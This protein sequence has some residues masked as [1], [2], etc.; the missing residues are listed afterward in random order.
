MFKISQEKLK[1]IKELLSILSDQ[2]N[3]YLITSEHI[4]EAREV[5]T[6]L[7]EEFYV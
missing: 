1:Q 6:E 4:K 7:K 2:N 5:I 3:R